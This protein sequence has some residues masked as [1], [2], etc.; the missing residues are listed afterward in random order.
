MN[1]SEYSQH[2]S[3]L[4]R[5][6]IGIPRNIQSEIIYAAKKEAT[7]WSTTQQ[8]ESIQTIDD[9][10]RSIYSVVEEGDYLAGKVTDKNGQK[11]PYV[12]KNN[13]TRRGKTLTIKGPGLIKN[14][15]AYLKKE[16]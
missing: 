1:Q 14:I 2:F 4:E 5:F 10:L 12:P 3:N 8:L 11:C 16:F 7:R 13:I 9:V 6:L 15:A